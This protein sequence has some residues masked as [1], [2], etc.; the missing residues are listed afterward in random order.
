MMRTHVQKVVARCFAA[1]RQL[2]QIR[3]LLTPDTLRTL[4]TALVLSRLDYGNSVLVGL[5]A[6]LVQRLQ[7][8]LNASARLIYRLRR[9]DHITDALICLHWLRVT[10]RVNFKIAVLTFKLLHGAAPSYLGPLTRVSEQSGTRHLR[11]A[12][13]G[14][15]VVPPHKLSTV[16]A[17]AFSVVAPSFWNCLPLDVTSAPSVSVF[18]KR[19]KTFLFR[20]SFR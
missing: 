15:L 3:H 10:E 2:R 5:P 1:L 9:S 16:G 8:V 13:L 17:R 14:R 4:I 12:D 18:R 20:L 7:S 19:L 6:Y 11:S